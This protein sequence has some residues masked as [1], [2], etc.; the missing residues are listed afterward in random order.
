MT[1]SGTAEL[2]LRNARITTLDPAQPTATALA[3]TGGSISAIGAEAEVM[4]QV[5]PGTRVVDALNRRVVPGLIDSHL[6]IIRGGNHFGAELRWD[7]VG[8]LAQALAML[9]EQAERTPAGQWVRVIGGWTAAQ[10]AEHRMPTL[11]ETNA[12]APD[13]PVMVLH[14][15]QSALLNRAAL[16][17]VDIG[18]STPDT[19]GA[20][21]VRDHAG[22]PTGMLLA[23]PQAGIL[24]GTIAKAPSLD[25]E[26]RLNG[27][28]RFQAELNR[29]GLTGAIDAAGGFQTYPDDYDAVR[30][31]ARRG[32]LTVRIAYNLMPQRPGHEV[33][34]MTAWTSTA[35]PGDGDEW[36]RLNGAGEILVWAGNDLEIFAEPR[37]IPPAEVDAELE[38]ALRVLSGAGWGFRLHSTYDETMQRYLSVME[39]VAADGGLQGS[40]WFFDH[41]ET[42]TRATL[43]RSPR[44]A[45]GSPCRTAWRSRRSRS[46][47]GTAPVG[48]R[49]RRR[50]RT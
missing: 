33:E 44:S 1:D 11:T 32:E 5:G 39:R 50:S 25:A 31:L 26:Q 17:A 27:T 14:L 10:L 48:R 36:L 28:R 46:S 19:D 22:N 47:T 9:R 42:A 13:T 23:T 18:A 35:T 24:Y 7:G 3:V 29:F 34:D 6:H 30:E 45:A 12:A 16:R 43:D 15:Y 38:R 21:I 49:P 41:A 4:R 37:V 40:R 2:V 8:S 20:Q